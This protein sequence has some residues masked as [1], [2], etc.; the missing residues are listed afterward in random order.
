MY[1]YEAGGESRLGS[2]DDPKIEEVGL[3]SRRRRDY[4]D[5][6]HQFSSQRSTVQDGES[7]SPTLLKRSNYFI[8]L[9]FS[10]TFTVQVRENVV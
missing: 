4:R 9:T 2:S 6:Y 10:V 8:T 5:P 1:I 3:G 7:T